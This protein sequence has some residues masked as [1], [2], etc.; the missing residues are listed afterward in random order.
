MEDL[1]SCTRSNGVSLKSP[2]YSIPGGF[3]SERQPEEEPL[4]PSAFL[5]KDYRNNTLV[6]FFLLET[7]QPN[8]S[9]WQDRS[10]LC[11]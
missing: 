10:C 2:V 9:V 5:E 6:S 3:V 8:R 11:R 1:Q 4:L 7:Y